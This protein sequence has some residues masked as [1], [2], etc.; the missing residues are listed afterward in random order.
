MRDFAVQ[1]AHLCL[2][3]GLSTIELFQTVQCQNPELSHGLRYSDYL[4][5]AHKLEETFLL[6]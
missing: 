6:L 5:K 1:G 2:Y 3:Y 4:E